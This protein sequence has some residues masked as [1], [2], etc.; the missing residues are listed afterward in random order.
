MKKNKE[1]DIKPS[2]LLRIGLGGV[3]IYA[4]SSIITTPARW[5]EYL[6]EW[7]NSFM[8]SKTFLLIYGGI[9]IIIGLLILFNILISYISFF[10]FLNI[11]IIMIF[12][13]LNDYTFQNFGLAMAVL[14]LFILSVKK[15]N[16][17]INYFG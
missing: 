4:G 11:F 15:N 7:V 6:P 9:Q 2:L 10:A 16:K 1:I 5:I 12:T 13:G 3:F 14:S 8:F 17:Q